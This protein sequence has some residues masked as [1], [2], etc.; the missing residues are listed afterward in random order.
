MKVSQTSGEGAP[1]SDWN[2]VLL[3]YQMY[4]P[5]K[6]KNT[7]GSSGLAIRLRLVN[8]MLERVLETIQQMKVSVYNDIIRLEDIEPGTVMESKSILQT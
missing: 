6:K 2:Q 1:P 7:N 8:R 3:L 5:K 4:A